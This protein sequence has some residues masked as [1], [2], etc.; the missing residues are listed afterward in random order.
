M[1][2]EAIEMK[3]ASYPYFLVW[4]DERDVF[5]G[6]NFDGVLRSKVSEQSKL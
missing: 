6:I 4:V 5:E 2:G 3:E 1:Y